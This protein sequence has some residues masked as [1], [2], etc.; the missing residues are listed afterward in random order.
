MDKLKFKFTLAK[1][2]T[3]SAT[4]KRYTVKDTENPYLQCRVSPTGG[5]S[6]SI[7]RKPRGKHTAVR[8]TIRNTGSMADIKAEADAI[9]KQLSAGINP[10]ERQKEEA[11]LDVT[12][13]EAF[14]KYVASKSLAP[15]TLKSYQKALDRMDDWK[16]KP[17]RDITKLMVLELYNELAADSHTAAMKVPQVL[18]AVWNF[19]NDLTDDDAFGRSPTTVLNKQKKKWSRTTTRNRK[20]PA[21]KLPAWLDAVRALPHQQGDGE[22]M[23]AYLE[24]LLLT[25]LRRREAGYLRWENVNLKDGYFIVRAT[26]NHSDHCLPITCR[27]RQLLH[28]MRDNGELVFGVEEPKKAINRVTAV[29]DVKFSSHDLRRTFTTLADHSGA[30]QYAI[31]GILN[32]SPGNDVTGTHYAAYRPLDDAG[33]VDLSEV[34][35]M[36]EPLQKIEDY[37]LSKAKA[38]RNNVLEVVK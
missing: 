13:Q 2:K 22:R 33:N 32:H 17:M 5:R 18:R 16:E 1:L 15:N 21:D 35:S 26:K 37:I 6:L 20:I 10:N 12:L 8:V 11:A 29:C 31:K 28:S 34:E 4:G 25:G 7:Y 38:H 27:T 9:N 23:A 14:D 3:L 19:Q 24:F 30:G 36:R